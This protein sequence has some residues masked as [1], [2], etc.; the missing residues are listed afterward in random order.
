MSNIDATAY[1]SF[2]R[3][4]AEGGDQSYG[5]AL[6]RGYSSDRI[7]SIMMRK[8]GDD[9]NSGGGLLGFFAARMVLAG[10]R[11]TEAYSNGESI[12]LQDMPNNPFTSDDEHGGNLFRYSADV[13]FEGG[14]NA[15]TVYGWSSN[16]DMQGLFDD[17]MERGIDIG[18]RYPGKFGLSEG[19]RP[20]VADVRILTMRSSIPNGSTEN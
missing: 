4:L 14:S 12:T 16:F 10:N 11:A 20:T 3:I 6:A 19:E 18:K 13:Y 1:D 7:S 8:F 2:G 9:Y 5:L 17:A 15:I